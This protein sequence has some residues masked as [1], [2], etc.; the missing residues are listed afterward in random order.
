MNILSKL[1]RRVTG[2]EG[3]SSEKSMPRV[4]PEVP[5]INPDILENGWVQMAEIMPRYLK[6][7]R[8]H[9]GRG[10]TGNSVFFMSS[11]LSTA[12]VNQELDAFFP[13]DDVFRPEEAFI[14]IQD[15]LGLI[16]D[17]GRTTL[18]MMNVLKTL[19]KEP[20]PQNGQ[21][22]KNMMY[23]LSLMALREVIDNGDVYDFETLRRANNFTFYEEDAATP[24][25]YF[26]STEG[27]VGFHFV[28][29]KGHHQPVHR[30]GGGRFKSRK[31]V[32]ST[33]RPLLESGN[34]GPVPNDGP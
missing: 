10:F 20:L 31:H 11:G 9:A 4:I 22:Q 17:S 26:S 12:L 3:G 34:S 24:P 2:S 8:Q 5:D 1:F 27:D 14:H 33:H 32:A 19:R 13:N 7:A 28:L 29:R 15:A 6:L 21:D 23:A 18:G 30:V 16:E 25:P